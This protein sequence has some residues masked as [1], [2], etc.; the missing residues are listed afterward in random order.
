M[1]GLTIVCALTALLLASLLSANTYAQRDT[2]PMIPGS[3]YE[4]SGQ[5]RSADNR[6]INNVI[7]RLE[8]MS[9]ALVD[10]GAADS[11]GRFRFARL[12]SGQYRVSAKAA[13]VVASPQAVD[14]SRA[15]PRV[16]VLL[17]MVPETPTF[18]ARESAR[19]GVVD[20]RV[21]VLAAAALEKGRTALA[22]SKLDEAI[23]HL[24]NAISIH[25][26]FYEAHFLLGRL[27]MDSS[28]WPK[29][30]AAM[31]QA[32]RINPKAVMAL[33]SLGEVYRR[34]KKYDE[35]K[36]LLEESLKLDN[37]SWETHF[38]L[39]RI[40][41]ELKDIAKAGM[42]VA[43]TIELQPDLPEARLLAGNIFIRAGLPGNALVEYEEYLRLA[44]NGEFSGQARALVDK[45]RKSLPAK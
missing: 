25:S 31:R 39:G 43:R 34:Q 12:R 21:P 15:S 36:K 16:H 26:E 37:N 9:G 40:H 23:V 7:V 5:V 28:Q 11:L 35:G 14:L 1:S 4:V 29:A 17:Q 10:E 32:V 6:I 19:A 42:H 8:T 38:T 20:A 30:E 27:Y 18:R 44:P 45:L 22:N 41:W 13:G 33:V 3:T 2:D 24:Q